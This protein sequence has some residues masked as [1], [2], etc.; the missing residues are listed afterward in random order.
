MYLHHHAGV[1][2]VLGGQPFIHG[3][4]GPLD[5]VGGGAL[6]GCVDGRALG[7]LLHLLV[8]GVDF[9]QVQPAAGKGFHVP[10]V[11]GLLADPVHV[12]QHARI[13]LEIAV[14]VVLGHLAVHFQLP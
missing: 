14:D 5:D 9:R 12:R 10:I 13:A 1:V 7:G 4:H 6:H 3:N 11:M 2:G 8:A